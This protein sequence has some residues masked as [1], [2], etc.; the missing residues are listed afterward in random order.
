MNFIMARHS[1]EKRLLWVII[2]LVSKVKIK[3][4]VRN[5]SGVDRTVLFGSP[6]DEPQ[7]KLAVS[8][9]EDVEAILANLDEE[10]KRVL[11]EKLKES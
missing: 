4:E 8:E 3:K 6:Y 7:Q 1:M 10:T 9:K 5:I 2:Y 11:A